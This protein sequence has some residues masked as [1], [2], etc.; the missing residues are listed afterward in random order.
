MER[1]GVIKHATNES[2]KLMGRVDLVEV[3][4]KAREVYIKDDFGVYIVYDCAFSDM[5]DLEDELLKIGSYYISKHE[6]LINTELEKPYPLIDR[7]S[8]ME[9]LLDKES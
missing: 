6:S 8:L 9:D 4:E 3:D 1:I 7:M 2:V 5:R